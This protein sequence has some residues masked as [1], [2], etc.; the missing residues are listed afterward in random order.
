MSRPGLDRDGLQVLD[1][2]H[3]PADGEH[4]PHPVAH[5]TVGDDLARAHV[6]LDE[7]G[8]CVGGGADIRPHLVA[9][10]RTGVIRESPCRGPRPGCASSSRSPS[11]AQTPGPRIASYAITSSVDRRSP[12][13][14][15]RGAQEDLFDVGFTAFRE[16]GVLVAARDDDR[17]DVEPARRHEMAGVVLSQ[18]AQADHAVEQ[19]AL[20]GRL[21]VVDDEVT[22]RQDVATGAA[23]AGDEVAGA[24]VRISNGN[25]PPASR[26]ALQRRRR[27]RRGG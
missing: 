6:A 12:V 2:V 20:D 21:D 1:R 19:R 25:S 24:V 15:P 18:E 17:R 8:E 7:V 10:A 13:T 3:R 9:R 14:R 26:I 23:G 16:A 27:C 5:G 4:R 22:A 11:P